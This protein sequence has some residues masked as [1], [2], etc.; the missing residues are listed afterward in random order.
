[1]SGPRIAYTDFVPAA[2]RG[3]AA[4]SEALSHGVLGQRFVELVWLRVSQINGCAYCVDRHARALLAEGEDFQRINSLVTWREVDFYTP[5]ERAAFAW[6]E[7]VNALNH[8]AIDARFESLAEHFD[9]RE[10]AELTAAV[11][12]MNAWN[13]IAIAG[14]NPVARAPLQ[15]S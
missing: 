4:A 15:A 2:Y 10:V 5:R 6:A 3:L 9:G 1:M 8:T 7:A 12:L 11:A 13:R 14:H